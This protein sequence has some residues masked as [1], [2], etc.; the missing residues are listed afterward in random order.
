MDL[1]LNAHLG[2]ELKHIVNAGPALQKISK[3]RHREKPQKLIQTLGLKTTIF[4]APHTK[5]LRHSLIFTNSNGREL[6]LPKG[7]VEK[8][9]RKPMERTIGAGNIVSGFK[10]R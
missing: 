2:S 4:Q 3:H 5:L 9:K 10:A 8:E 1:K 6:R 7:K